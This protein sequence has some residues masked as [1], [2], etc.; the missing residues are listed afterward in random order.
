M[1]K[2]LIIFIFL[3]ISV[4]LSVDAQINLI[5]VPK[6][7]ILKKSDYKIEKN[8]KLVSNN[9]DSF[10]V[11]QLSNC[12]K[13]ELNIDL[14]LKKKAKEN[15][16]EFIKAGSLE[17]YEIIMKANGLNLDFK[18]DKEGYI[19]DIKPQ[20]I[21]IISQS[22]AGIF[23]GIQTLKQIIIANRKG[24]NIPCLLIYDYPDIPVRAWQDDI[25]RGPIPTMAMMKEQI[26]KMSSYK[27]NYFS[28]YIEHVFKLEKHPGIAPQ[29]GITQAQIEE[30]SA[31][32]KK[33]HVTLIGS[34]QS[35]GHMEE[36]LSHPDYQYLAENNHIISP[37]LKESYEFLN[38]VYQE[39][40][41]V[42][43]GEYFNI[44]CDET[45]GLGEGK[46]KVMVDSMGIDG[47]YLYHINKLN[48][49]LKQFDKKILMWGDIISSYPNIIE[50]LP[51]NIT[52]M[53]WGYHA[54]DNFEYAITPISETGLNFWVAPG[55][56]CW[57][58]IFPNYRET[59]IN[60][61]NFIRD[62]YRHNAT[63]VLNTS[64]DD[65]GLNFFQ[66]NWHGFIWG[67][68]NCWNA[69]H[70]NK[71]VELSN[72][73]RTAKY[74]TFNESFD[75]IFYGLKNDSLIPE[76]IKFSR[77]HQSGVKDILKNSR[78]FE[79]IFPIHLQYVKQKENN[80]YLLNQLD[81][82]NRRIE[83]V[84]LK[85]TDN[86]ITID[87]L[88]FAISQVEFT[89]LKNIFRIELYHF[90]RN[91]EDISVSEIKISIDELI[92]KA[93]LLKTEYTLLWNQ[94]NRGYWLDKNKQKFDAL[95]ENLS[96]LEGHCI[97]TPSVGLS[98]KGRK[99]SMKSLF[100]DLPIYYSTVED[101]P[102]SSY[103]KYTEPLFFDADVYLKA[104]AINKEKTYNIS[105][106]KLIY[107][108]G[109]GKLHKLN[110]R[111]SAY[112]P[113]YDGGGNNALL[114]GKLGIANNLR[115]GKW[116]GYSGQ[117]IDI[118]ID[119]D[120]IQTLN[121][122]SMGFYQNTETWVIFPKKIDIYVKNNFNDE[123]QLIKEIINTIPPEATGSLKHSYETKFENLKTRYIKIVAHYYGKLPEWHRAGSKYESM[124]FSDEIILK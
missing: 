20:T 25:S 102:E 122:F 81:S 54:A 115:S 63:G 89:L 40:V 83:S 74:N 120:S 11:N 45:F 72:K 91:E 109:I 65:D 116:Q 60:V 96:N 16:I 4:C 51:D 6:Q 104:R 7:L 17:E 23:Y 76:I 56:N 112:H 123:Y 50:K 82:L 66:N 77:L 35:F 79:P 108:K 12:I 48:A 119:L 27:L 114:D 124:I 34:Y 87:Y 99:I 44:N 53:A 105:E 39:I 61:Y 97:I 49:M 86:K 95:I 43:D 118:E 78:F 69:P 92:E 31:F 42:F 3:S 10:Y 32:A 14:K 47:V 30:L 9:L 59:E 41:P 19:I 37:A 24:A 67:A 70:Y 2:K 106:C 107:H 62:G 8:T 15:Y 84:S 13:Q 117:N 101:T 113:S 100:G 28:L 64:W 58:N 85:V 110:S 75:A 93:K 94:E 22:D 21:K 26:E 71:S 33:H 36:T 98:E 29:D 55:V 121:Y 80:E 90:I 38:D 52:V 103:L 57:S 111:C 5:P 18:T 1:Q 68:E 73:E 46:S 88:K